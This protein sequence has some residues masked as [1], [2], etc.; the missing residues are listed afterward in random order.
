MTQRQVQAIFFF[1]VMVI[2]GAIAFFILRDYLLILGVA[3]TLAILFR[4]LFNWF[5]RVLHLHLGGSAALTTIVMFFIFAV[6]LTG[7]IIL[8]GTEVREVYGRV[9]GFLD[10]ERQG[11][12]AA[13]P[14][15]HWFA[16][17]IRERIANNG[18]IVSIVEFLSRNVATVFSNAGDFFFSTFLFFIAF[19]YFTKDG[20]IFR[21]KLFGISPLSD[22][23]EQKIYQRVIDAINAVM[24]GAIIVAVVQ[25]TLAGLG[26]WMFGVG[27]PVLLGVFTTI[28]SLIPMVGTSLVLVPTIAYLFITGS[29]ASGIGL[30]IWGGIAVGLID[31]ILKPK[32]IEQRLKIHPL[33]ILL[34]IIGGI[35]V[36]GFLGFIVGP[37][38]LSVSWALVEI[39]REEF[40]PYLASTFMNE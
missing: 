6:P 32:L 11:T 21:Q 13:S 36:F 2:V 24:R 17:N 25:G 34:S 40:H 29:T 5:R 16:E 14:L 28:A 26:F 4:P 22:A 15:M 19:Y 38:I 10:A 7:F 31:N 18:S 27:A 37:L 33:L 23:S 8:L 30:A 3:L 9:L 35:D 20:N 12:I 1:S 39:Y